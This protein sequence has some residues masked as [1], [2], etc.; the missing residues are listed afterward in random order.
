MAAAMAAAL[1]ARPVVERHFLV[2]AGT[3]QQATLRLAVQGLRSTLERYAPIP[4]LIAER[5]EL[6]SYLAH[7]G[8]GLLKVTVIRGVEG[9]RVHSL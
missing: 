9:Y 6:R 7:P 2:L 1:V 5:P 8:N 3:E 4:G